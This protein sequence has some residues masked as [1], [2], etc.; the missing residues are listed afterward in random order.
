MSAPLSKELRQKYGVRSMP[1]RKEDEIKV[2]RGN[3]KDK[4]GN[5]K[6]VYRKKW[7]VYMNGGTRDKL[8]GMAVDVGVHPSNVVITRLHENKDRLALVERKKL[9]RD[10]VVNKA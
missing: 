5:V 6:C 9:R 2:V 4:I 10:A 8:N 3:M 1:V 7:M